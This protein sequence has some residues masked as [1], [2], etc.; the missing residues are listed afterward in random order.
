MILFS[1]IMITSLNGHIVS[2]ESISTYEINTTLEICN[3]YIKPAFD[4]KKNANPYV[5]E[6]ASECFVNRKDTP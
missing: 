1:I 5:L 3:K 2:E 4:Q 6:I